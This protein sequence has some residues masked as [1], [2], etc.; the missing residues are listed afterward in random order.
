MRKRTK[1]VAKTG[2][3]SG[4]TNKTI[5][6]AR[7]RP[8]LIFYLKIHSCCKFTSHCETTVFHASLLNETRNRVTS[9]FSLARA[10]FSFS[11]W[12]LKLISLLTQSLY[13]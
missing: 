4:T 2:K 1:I 5:S 8:F 11:R 12:R 13:F 3:I 7:K 10:K 9:F 6:N